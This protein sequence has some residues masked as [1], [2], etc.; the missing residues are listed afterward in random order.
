MKAKIYSECSVSI[1]GYGHILFYDY[2]NL[3][4][5]TVFWSV[6][7]SNGWIE[8]IRSECSTHFFFNHIKVLSLECYP[9]HK[10][11]IGVQRLQVL[12]YYK[13]KKKTA[14]SEN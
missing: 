5:V 9:N 11:A 6:L 12:E 7:H 10:A 3:S 14:V 1:Y 4:N 13:T 8:C 2:A